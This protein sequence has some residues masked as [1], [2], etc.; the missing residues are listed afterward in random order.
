M[1]MSHKDPRVSIVVR[2]YNRLERLR[3][4]LQSLR[5]QTFESFE[6]VIVNDAGED[7]A[8][9]LTDELGAIPFQYICN[10]QN[11]GRTAALNIGVE[12][13]KGAYIGF[14]DDDDVV[15]PDHIQTLADKAFSENLPVVYSDVLNV[16]FQQDPQTGE[17]KRMK[18]QLVYSFDFNADNFLLANYIPITCLLIRRDCFEAAGPF[19]ESLT[20]YEDWEFLIRLSR[21]FPF[22]H[23]AKV[24]GEYRRRDD[25]SNI[26]E[27]EQYPINERVVKRRYRDER[28]AAFD[29]IFKRTFQQQRQIRR[30]AAQ[31][32]QIVQQAA[33]W[34]DS[35]AAA[36]KTIAQL[37]QEITK[38]RSENSL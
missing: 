30:Q 11:M 2:T 37:Q 31:T 34:R 4:C 38:R 22:Q 6:A 7:A 9:A 36:Q 12:A 18:E 25:N 27:S 29:P 8:P 26:R 33:Q 5:R 17:W 32:Q 14:L 28:H 16:T 19:D 20:I 13:A 1:S 21:K 23:I 3:E 35:L 15:Y 10:A 24:T